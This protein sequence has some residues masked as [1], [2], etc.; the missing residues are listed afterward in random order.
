[1][2]RNIFQFSI[3]ITNTIEN[4]NNLGVFRLGDFNYFYH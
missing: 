4:E 3:Q 2:Q 1:M